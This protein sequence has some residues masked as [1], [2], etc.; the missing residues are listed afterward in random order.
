MNKEKNIAWLQS[1]V[2]F[3][4]SKIV[5]INKPRGIPTQGG[6]RI[7]FSIDHVLQSMEKSWK[8]VHRLDRETTGVMIFAKYR[9]IAAKIGQKFQQNLIKKTYYAVVQ[10]RVEKNDFIIDEPLLEKKIGNENLMLVDER[11]KS[12]ITNAQLMKY[13]KQLDQS[14]LKLNPQTGRKNQIRAHLQHIG[15]PIIG[16]SKYNFSERKKNKL[17][18]HAQRLQFSLGQKEIEIIAEFPADWPEKFLL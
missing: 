10:G 14:L 1:L 8:I 2:I 12:S 17:L 16:D 5:A 3:E 7:N 11:G 4:N 9:D 6:T 13:N 18:L 15:H